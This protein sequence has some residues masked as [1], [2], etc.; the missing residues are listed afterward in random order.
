MRDCPRCGKS[1]LNDEDVYNS[2]SHT[3]PG[4]I[5]CNDCGTN[6]ALTLAGAGDIEDKVIQVKWE[7]K[8]F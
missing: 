2:K 7:N 4:V 8:K 6:E 3:H 1:K 5:I